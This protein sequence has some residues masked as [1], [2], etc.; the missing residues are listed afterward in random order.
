MN[1][2]PQNF[3]AELFNN[4]LL[5]MLSVAVICFVVSEI[6]CNY[7]QVDK[8]WSL[9]PIAYAWMSV[10][11][12]PSPRILIMAI[13]VTVWGLRLSYNFYRKGGYHIIPWKGEEDYRWK[14]L[15][16]QP[17]FKSRLRFGIF[18]LLFIS[19]YQN[20]L[21]LLFS[22][23]LLL[24]ASNPAQ[25]LFI[26]DYIAAM[27]M[28][29]FIITE[30]VADNQL[31]R[32]YR[33]KNKGVEKAEIFRDS[34]RKGFMTEGLWKYSRHPNFASEQAIWISF[35]ML[36]VAASGEWLNF[37]ISGPLLLVL[38]FIGSSALTESISSKK[39]PEYAAYK[40][41]VPK[42]LPKLFR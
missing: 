18:N 14:F 35:Y 7:S 32:F 9:M 38:L 29:G 22:T 13:L 25:D 12:A 27:L 15:R 23:P 40:R 8:L 19:L 31:F 3:P 6:T 39:Y 36:G 28:L 20:L 11:W 33:E 30:S 37:S 10:A 41:S 16:E 2:F 34:V 24:A 21:I 17:L 4:W 42:F 1:I 26:T 5:L